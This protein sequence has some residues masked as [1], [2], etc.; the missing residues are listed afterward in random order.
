MGAPGERKRHTALGPLMA[1]L[2]PWQF[3]AESGVSV[4]GGAFAAAPL[5]TDEEVVS[6]AAGSS[7]QGW[8]PLTYGFLTLT[9]RRLIYTPFRWPISLIE[10]G[11]RIFSLAEIESVAIEPHFKPDFVPPIAD[12][13]VVRAAGRS[14]LFFVL[15]VLSWRKA[16]E[17]Q[18]AM[19][20]PGA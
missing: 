15:N 12:A 20:S 10:R 11:A 13:L 9:N 3:R 6:V 7:R 16:V 1:S 5:E 18:K 2:G 4:G 14:R 19:A 8:R 17:E